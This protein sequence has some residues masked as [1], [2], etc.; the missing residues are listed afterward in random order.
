MAAIVE[1][2]L[3][4]CE[5][6]RPKIENRFVDITFDDFRKDQMASVKLV[7]EAAG[8]TLTDEAE[9]L[10]AGWIVANSLHK[11]G[12]RAYAPEDVG[13]TSSDLQ[14]KFAFYRMRFQ[15]PG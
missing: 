15:P 7:Y 12:K 1:R 9:A 8:D 6:A 5:D 14:A 4:E 2:L 13:L 10:M 3:R 11:H